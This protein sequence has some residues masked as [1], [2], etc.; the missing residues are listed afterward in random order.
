[1]STRYIH[2]LPVTRNMIIRTLGDQHSL[3]LRLPGHQMAFTGRHCTKMRMQVVLE[4]IAVNAMIPR[5][6]LLVQT[7]VLSII[8]M[9]KQATEIS[10]K[11]AATTQ[12]AVAIQFICSTYMIWSFR[13]LCACSPPPL[14]AYIVDTIVKANASTYNKWIRDEAV[15]MRGKL[16][17]T[18]QM[19]M[20]TSSAP[21]Q[22]PC[23][24]RAIIRRQTKSPLQL[25]SNHKSATNLL[26][27]AGLS[28]TAT[29]IRGIIARGLD[30]I[31]GSQNTGKCSER[32]NIKPTEEELI[33]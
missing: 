30:L 9:T 11:Q 7:R 10:P 20:N 5:S 17:I 31:E 3:P 29:M 4:R 23:L 25:S 33:L 2:S 1:M 14:C 18:Q 12:I 13:R 27:R 6:S 15:K 24:K 28:M 22:R 8:R 19:T 21:K 32:D 16:V 26:V